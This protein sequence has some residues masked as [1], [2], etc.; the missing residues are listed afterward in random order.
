MYLETNEL[1]NAIEAYDN[2]NSP[3]GML[4]H[5]SQ[6]RKKDSIGR[7]IL[8]VLGALILFFG[9]DLSTALIALIMATFGT[10]IEL[11]LLRNI[12]HDLNR[13]VPLPNLKR[14]VTVASVAQALGVTGFVSVL[15]TSFPE[16]AA[17]PLCL[18]YL[19]LGTTDTIIFLSF[20][21]VAKWA[22]LAIYGIAAIA[23]FV[24]DLFVMEYRNEQVIYNFIATLIIAYTMLPFINYMMKIRMRDLNQQR[25]QLDQALKLARSNASLLDQQRESRRLSSIAENALDSII[26][27]D[28]QARIIWINGAFTS[29]TGYTLSEVVGKHPS[30]CL[31]GPRSNPATLKHFTNAIRN[32]VSARGENVNY[33]KTGDPFWVET[34]LSPVFD[35][36]GNLEMAIS[37]DRDITQTKKRESELAE[38]KHAAELS[39]RTQASFLATIS[40]EIRTPMN[41][42]IGM[43]DLLNEADL[44]PEE[45]L[46]VQTIQQSSQ[47]LLTIINDILDFSKL[48]DGHLKINPVAF[49]LKSCLV[50]VMNLM[51]P[52]AAAKSLDLT[53]DCAKNLPQIVWG[54]DG[55]LRQI[56]INVIGNAIKFTESGSVDITVNTA[57][58]NSNSKL[59]ISVTDTGIGIPA[60]RIDKMFD[61]FQQADATTTRQFGGTGLGLAISRQLSRLMGGD[62]T[63]T[64]NL[65]IGSC[66]VIQVDCPSV[67]QSIKPSVN[68][69]AIPEL[70]TLEGG[71][72]LLAEDNPTNRLIVQKLL[73]DLPITLLI[74][75]D[76]QEAVEKVRSCVPDII[77]MDMSMPNMDGL[78]ATRAIRKMPQKQP[79]IIALTANAHRSDYEACIRAGMDSFLT[80]P[81][82]RRDMMDALAAGFQMRS[83]ND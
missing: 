56:L 53:L 17:F 43:S 78:A 7:V 62:I 76:G 33:T 31:H 18:S 34:N 64:S 52:Q 12:E 8:Y 44:G 74:A 30:E 20:H 58:L 32:G 67:N 35:E 1:R 72:V 36:N 16:E 73:K 59:V 41:G 26:M 54:D 27:L 68:L 10:L 48:Q 5:Y 19:A 9:A 24:F 77:L 2:K 57:D 3:S 21:R 55:R 25:N 42:I 83:H 11:F 63:A 6:R 79:H 61:Q 14:T 69:Q 37:V 38:A 47:A 22:K 28:P 23:L 50:E 4:L 65:G 40:H 60:D 70:G 75:T 15:W 13:Q 71:T 66:F 45:S 82:R 81:V 29:K 39:E 51:R 49:D 46:Y 80:K